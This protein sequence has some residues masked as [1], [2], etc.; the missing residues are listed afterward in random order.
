M[1]QHDCQQ[2]IAFVKEQMPDEAELFSLAE[3][4]KVFSDSTRIQIMCALLKKELCVFDITSLLGVSQSAVSHQLRLLRSSHLVKTR[5]D[6]KN[7][8]YSLDDDH[9]GAII[10]MGLDHIGHTIPGKEHSD[11]NDHT[12][13]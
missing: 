9:V 7:I 11:E 6:G 5:R 12:K 13:K 8:F 10:Q 1:E 3:L 2:A 4:F